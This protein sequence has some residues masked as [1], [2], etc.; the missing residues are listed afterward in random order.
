MRVLLVDDEEKF[1][2]VLAKRLRLRGVDADYACSGEEAIR[3]VREGDFDVA[4]LDVNMPG[5]GGIELRRRLAAIAP[6]MRFAFVT[7]HGSVDDHE[8]GSAV[9]S[10]YLAKPLQIDELVETLDRLATGHTSREE[11][12]DEH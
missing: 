11:G 3:I 6:S 7:G 2:S 10:A 5:I 1:V 12:P 4:L 9:V 8:T